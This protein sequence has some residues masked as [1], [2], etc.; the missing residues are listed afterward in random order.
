MKKQTMTRRVTTVAKRTNFRKKACLGSK[1]RSKLK[2]K[3]GEP[4][5]RGKLRTALLQ[6]QSRE[7]H[8]AGDDL[9]LVVYS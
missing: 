2:R 5:R 8:Q 7:A 1:W 6:S 3:I 4:L 9:R